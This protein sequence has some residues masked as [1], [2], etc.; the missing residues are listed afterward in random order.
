MSGDIARLND[1]Q[2][3]PAIRRRRRLTDAD[4]AREW[5]GTAAHYELADTCQ[6]VALRSAVSINVKPT[7]NPHIIHLSKRR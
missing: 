5:R 4:S 2:I 6:N 7:D 3:A 1:T